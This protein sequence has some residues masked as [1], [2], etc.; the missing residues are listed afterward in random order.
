MYTH[1]HGHAHIRMYTHTHTYA[2]T[3]AHYTHA[4]IH[5]HLHTY[6]GGS[7]KN[8]VT[9]S[10]Q[11][12]GQPPRQS[13]QSAARPHFSQS[14]MGW[15]GLGWVGSRIPKSYDTTCFSGAGGGG[16]GGGGGE[17]RHLYR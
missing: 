5:T 7:E 1:S 10:R 14:Q 11:T 9:A 3:H 13:Q 17:L 12:T 8:S 2:C 16:G 15:V 6:T 4:Q